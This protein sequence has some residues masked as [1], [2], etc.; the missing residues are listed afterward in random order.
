MA[1]GDVDKFDVSDVNICLHGG[2]LISILVFY[3][4]RIWQLVSADRELIVP[5]GIATAPAVVLGLGMKAT[6][7]DAL[8]SSPL[9]AGCLLPVTGFILIWASRHSSGRGEYRGLSYKSAR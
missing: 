9:L 7:A 4:L 5:L 1:D 8:L 2:T 3:W 6:G